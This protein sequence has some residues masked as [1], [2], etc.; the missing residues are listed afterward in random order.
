MISIVWFPSDIVMI[1]NYLLRLLYKFCCAQKS[2][3]ESGY[4]CC[5]LCIEIGCRFDP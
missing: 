1:V 5:L 3:L 4:Y 2:Y